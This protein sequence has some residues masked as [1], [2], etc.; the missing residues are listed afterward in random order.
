MYEVVRI[1]VIFTNHENLEGKYSKRRNSLS[2][3]T[4]IESPTVK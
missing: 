2:R 1:A 4:I 3:K